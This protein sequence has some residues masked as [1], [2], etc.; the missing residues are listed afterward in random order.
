M[1]VI[2]PISVVL[3]LVLSVGLFFFLPAAITSLIERLTGPLDAWLKSV[4][5]GLLKMT[6]FVVYMLLVTLMPEIRRTFEYHGSEHKS[7]FCYEKGLPLTVENVRIQ[8]RFHP[9]CGTSFMIVMM[10]ISIVVGIFIPWEWADVNVRVL[11]V[12]IR[13]AFKILLVPVICGLGYEF[14]MYAGKH[15][16]LLIR[17]LSAPGLLMQR[18]TTREPSDDMIEVAIAAL[19]G[20]L[21]EEFPEEN[22]ENSAEASNQ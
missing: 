21:P 20:A 11:N 22:N 8:R 15:D 10:I 12:L 18:I 14:L 3:A 9:R 2:M 19:K 5:E 7:I 17:I 4:A 16:N 1:A 13:M 6:I